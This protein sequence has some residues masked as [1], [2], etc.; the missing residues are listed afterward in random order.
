M[1]ISLALCV[2]AVKNL[3]IFR[4]SLNKILNAQQTLLPEAWLIHLN[5]IPTK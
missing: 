4:V 5:I 1:M 3:S 2:A